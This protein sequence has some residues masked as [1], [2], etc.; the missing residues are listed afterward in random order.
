MKLRV[1]K[2]KNGTM[3]LYV[4]K[5]YRDK[6]GKSTSKIVEK[7]GTY[8]E[9]L[10]EHD[11]PIAWAKEYVAKLNEQEKEANRKVVV[12]F[13]PTKRV[14]FDTS[15]LFNCG[16]IFLQKIYHELR[17][18]RICKEIS[19]EYKFQYDLD[20]ILSRLI[21]GRI[22]FPSSKLNTLEES[23][24]LLEQPS[25]ELH[26]IYRALDVLAEKA[27]YIQAEVYKNSLK[28]GKRNAGILYYDC[29]NYY[30]EM[31]QADGLKQYGVSKEHRPNPIVEMGMFMDGDGLP[32]AYCLHAGNTNEQ[33]TL[34]PLEKEILEKYGRE[35][36][37]VCTDAGLSS[38]D[39]RKFN[40]R[41]GRAFVTVQSIKKMLP[42]QKKFALSPEKWHLPGEK[43]TFTMEDILKDEEGNYSK[44]YYKEEWFN[45]NGIDQR[46]IVTFSLKYRDYLRGLRENDIA[47]ANKL[48]ENGSVSKT[49]QTDARRLIKKESFSSDDGSVADKHVFTIDTEKIQKEEMYDGFYCVATNLEDSVEE[50]IRINARRWEIEESFRIMKS[51]FRAR[52]VYLSND[53]R[54]KA[55]FLTCY[56]ALVIYRYLEKRLEEKFTVSEITCT[57]KNMKLLAIEGEGYI[58]A[59]APNNI[60]D[61]LHETFGFR[62]DYQINTTRM[63]KKVLSDSKKYTKK[64]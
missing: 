47:R 51:D 37:I 31:E 19:E 55:H 20:D 63:M 52:P 57:L 38:Y 36:F 9:L 14:D 61:A 43:E 22:L 29:T 11:D 26:D 44:T 46:F 28:L 60:T 56:L 21:Y 8:D 59:Y 24:T 23:K 18:D 32:L 15:P 33:T 39:S 5:G 4:H 6:N 41:D 50:I 27:D 25:F 54:I 16:Y 3:N 30:F 42:H 13:D 64:G 49:R 53:E 1:D 40:N 45:D 17:L 7:L 34:V 58:P 62:T 48:I 12:S 35:K 2:N 10:K